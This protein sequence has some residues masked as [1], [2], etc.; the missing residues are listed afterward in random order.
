M[1]K[2]LLALLPA[3]W[4]EELKKWRFAHQIKNSRFFTDEPEYDILPDLISPGDWVLDIGANVGHYTCR[5]SE[6]V[7]PAGRVLAFEPIPNTFCLLS[8]NA[9]FFK[10]SNVSLFSLAISRTLDVVGMSVPKFDSGLN[11]YYQAHITDADEANYSILTFPID[12]LNIEHKVS[13]V[14]I[15]AEGHEDSVLEGMMALLAKHRPTLI[16][17]TVSEQTEA[18]LSGLGYHSEKLPGSPNTLYKC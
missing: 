5:F 4:Q 7:G 17:E 18:R 12:C 15:D 16:I 9:R 2:K 10:F 13:L 11:N 3:T 14:K 6:L 8:S 1:L